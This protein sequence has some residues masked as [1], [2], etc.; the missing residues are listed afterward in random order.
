MKTPRPDP[1][2]A[3]A[4]SDLCSCRAYDFQFG[5]GRHQ[6]TLVACLVYQLPLRAACSGAY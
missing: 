5:L 2:A 4:V 6:R 3:A 1:D